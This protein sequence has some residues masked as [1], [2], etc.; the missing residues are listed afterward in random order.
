MDHADAKYFDILQDVPSVPSTNSIT[1]MKDDNE[2]E[3]DIWLSTSS[4]PDL[5]A[6]AR[7]AEKGGIWT[8][9]SR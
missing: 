8:A 9:A 2:D 1:T 3:E 4:E 6:V 5:D 7:E